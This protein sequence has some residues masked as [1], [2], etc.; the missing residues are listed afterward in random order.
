MKIGDLSSGVGQLQEA[1][2]NLQRAWADTQP[3]WNDAS[4][5]N[6]EENHLKPLG[7]EVAGAYTAIQHLGDVLAKV[8][9][10]CEPW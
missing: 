7:S 4:S 9:R 3:H 10:D 2:E 1:L 8:R 5:R 6:L